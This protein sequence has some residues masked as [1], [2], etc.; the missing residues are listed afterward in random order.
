[1]MVCN[2]YGWYSELLLLG[3]LDWEELASK[4]QQQA[5]GR[6]TEV[7]DIFS[8]DNTLLSAEDVL[9]RHCSGFGVCIRERSFRK[10]SR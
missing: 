10:L 8:D 4:F 7:E 3:V 1:M 9:D 2:T 6:I 5:S